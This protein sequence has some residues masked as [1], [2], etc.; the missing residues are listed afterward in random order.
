M[1]KYTIIYILY[2]I[3]LFTGCGSEFGALL[4]GR[5]AKL[6]W[7]EFGNAPGTASLKS[8]N[9]DGTDH[10]T[11]VG[12][13]DNVND[14]A[15]DSGRKLIFWVED[16]QS[17]NDLIYRAN[18]NGSDRV[19]IIAE[20]FS[21][22]P[23]GIA[24]DINA[25]K[26]YWADA[27][28][29]GTIY[30]SDY[31][32]PSSSAWVTTTGTDTR[33]I[34][35][36]RAANYIYFSLNGGIKRAPLSSVSDSP[37][38]FIARPNLISGIKIDRVN[39]KIYWV[40]TGN[41]FRANLNDG[42]NIETVDSGNSAHELTLDLVNDKIYFSSKVMSAIYYKDLDPAAIA[43]VLIGGLNNPSGILVIN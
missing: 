43:E 35:I 22:G 32:G 13:L 6:Y 41:I 17:L 42:L 39:N 20:T 36:D 21:S 16:S 12:G 7:C 2:F 34:E 23:Y 37:S 11:I 40:E 15:V 14:L 19:N 1:K 27:G 28:V 5:G 31:G 30:S 4:E 8:A 10:K 29:S 25:S 33:D 24:L 18:I 3:C 9:L 26:V 38:F